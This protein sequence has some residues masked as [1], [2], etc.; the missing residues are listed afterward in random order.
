MRINFARYFLD[1]D[2]RGNRLQNARVTANEDRTDFYLELACVDDIA[3]Q[4]RE[5]LRGRNIVELGS[6]AEWT[7]RIRF[8]GP[9]DAW[10]KDLIDLLEEVL[11]LSTFPE[12]DVALALDFHQ[13]P[14]DAENPEWRKTP[15]GNLVY[16]KN[17]KPEYAN[18]ARN[19]AAAGNE[20]TDLLVGVIRAHPIYSAATRVI[21]V[22]STKNPFKFGERL[23]GAV[24]KRSG[25]EVARAK[26]LSTD[27]H[28]AKEGHASSAIEPYDIEGDVDGERVIIVDDLYRSGQTLRDIAVA[29]RANGATEVLG[30]ACTRA[31][32]RT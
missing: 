9:Y 1:E 29:A 28:Q 32:R 24:A 11:T 23:G 27:H 20:L 13:I 8:D 30:L 3:A 6:T 19:V 14:P 4:F 15:M 16:K 2:S 10:L 12:I 21:V 25:L 31:M 22:P 7:H 5:V 26:C 17:Y 18:S